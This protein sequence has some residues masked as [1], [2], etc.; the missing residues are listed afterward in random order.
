MEHSR[1]GVSTSFL[2]ETEACLGILDADP[3]LCGNL[4]KPGTTAKQGKVISSYYPKITFT[5]RESIRL[6]VYGLH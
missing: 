6:H 2:L 5:D 4:D 3:R 1:N